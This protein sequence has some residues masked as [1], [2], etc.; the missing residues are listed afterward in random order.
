MGY[1]TILLGILVVVLVI[2]LSGE[3]TDPLPQRV[4]QARQQDKLNLLVGLGNPQ[5]QVREA[6]QVELVDRF[7]DDIDLL[8]ES[9]LSVRACFEFCERGVNGNVD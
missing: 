6:L 8:S 9:F 1:V 3:H 2:L 5:G 7:L 4:L